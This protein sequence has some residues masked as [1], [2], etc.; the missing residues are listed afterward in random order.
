VCVR[1][2]RFE[3]GIIRLIIAIKRLSRNSRFHWLCTSSNDFTRFRILF[4]LYDIT[5]KI[6]CS[7][8][9]TTPHANTHVSV[10]CRRTICFIDRLRRLYASEFVSSNQSVRRPTRRVLYDRTL[11]AV[12]DASDNSLRMIRR[13][14]IVRE[15]EETNDVYRI[16]VVAT[17]LFR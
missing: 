9:A 1:L 10:A 4:V 17:W 2:S 14:E 6:Q 16:S 7:T 5:R 8:R 15:G 3:Y 11:T 13:R 12:R